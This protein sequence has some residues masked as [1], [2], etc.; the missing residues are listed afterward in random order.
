LVG[1]RAQAAVEYLTLVGLVL[2]VIAIVS[3]YGFFMYSESLAN[4]QSIEAQKQVLQLVND[5]SALGSGN[6]LVTNVNI[7]TT[8]VS[9]TINGTSIVMTKNSFNSNTT[10]LIDFNFLVLGRLPQS[11]GGWKIIAKNIDGN[12][13]LDYV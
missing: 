5:V 1:N 12:V 4:N 10:D 2:I 3:G 7:P 13:V 8:I 6:Q 11:S 9:W